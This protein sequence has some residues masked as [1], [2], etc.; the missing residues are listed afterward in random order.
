[1]AQ[2]NAW[3]TKFNELFSELNDPWN[4]EIVSNVVQESGWLQMQYTGKATFECSTATCNNRWTSIN[5]GARIYYRQFGS[6]TG[7][8][9]QHGK[10]K[11]FLG[12]Q[13]CLKCNGVF[14]NAMWHN[15]YIERAITKLLNKVKQKF[16]GLNVPTSTTGNAYVQADMSAPHQTGLCEFCA[17]GICQHGQQNDIDS[18]ASQFG[19]LDVNDDYD[20]VWDHDYDD[21]SDDDHDDVLDGDYDD[22][23][24][25]D[26][27]DVWDHDYYDQYDVYHNY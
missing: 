2:Q 17:M 22:V 25:D 9:S 15:L 14:E 8:Q 12:G 1:M 7:Q 18:I 27:D 4:L 24:D 19:H 3:E 20:D 6:N 26:Y 16:Y 11:L 10:V 23:S 5:A 13:K 21:V